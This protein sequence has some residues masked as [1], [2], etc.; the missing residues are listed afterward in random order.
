MKRI[1][2]KEVKKG[3]QETKVTT[4]KF[5]DHC[6]KVSKD[7]FENDPQFIEEVV[8][9]TQD[10]RGSEKAAE[11]SARLNQPLDK[12][13]I[14]K[15]MGKM[16]DGAPGEDGVRLSYLLNGGDVVNDRIVEIVQFMFRE[17][18]VGGTTL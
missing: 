2:L 13:E 17:D 16:K 5:R 18:A 14:L 8:S 4:A 12:E 1:G 9:S 6:S 7:R 3:R 15:Q 11:W 10:L